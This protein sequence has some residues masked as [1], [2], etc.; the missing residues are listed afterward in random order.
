MTKKA[1]TLKQKLLELQKKLPVITKDMKN[2]YFKSKYADINAYIKEIKPIATAVGLVLL[3]TIDVL[4]ENEGFVN[5]L[6]T[7]VI[8]PESGEEITGR[9]LLPYVDDPQ[10]QGALITYYRRY[11]IQSLFF[12]QAEDDD[13]N[14]VSTPSNDGKPQSGGFTRRKWPK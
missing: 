2:P 9:M 5:V 13:G 14:S 11:S 7:Q 6:K 12:M 3:Q 1:T 4:K 8:D 10:K